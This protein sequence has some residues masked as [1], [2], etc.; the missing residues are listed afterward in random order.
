VISP[1]QQRF[2]DNVNAAGGIGFIARND[3]NLDSLFNRD[4]KKV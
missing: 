4:Y 3:F 2:I 1:E